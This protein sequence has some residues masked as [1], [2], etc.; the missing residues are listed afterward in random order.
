MDLFTLKSSML[1]EKSKLTSEITVKNRYSRSG[2]KHFS[3]S[4]SLFRLFLSYD[5]SPVWTAGWLLMRLLPADAE[6]L[7]SDWGVS[8]MEIDT[9]RFAEA[10]ESMTCAASA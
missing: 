3:H 6:W 8:F 5:C 7:G 4:H 2:S 1:I 9:G 10:A